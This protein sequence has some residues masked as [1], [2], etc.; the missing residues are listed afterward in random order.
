MSLIQYIQD[1]RAEMQHVAWPTRTQTI[2]YTAMVIALSAFFAVYL[3]VFDHLFTSTL[4]RTLEVLPQGS[5]A[6]SAE[7]IEFEPTSFEAV[8]ADAA[9]PTES[10]I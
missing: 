9:S 5:A 8:P 4:G 2:I 3:G 10:A 1:T 7:T 6:P